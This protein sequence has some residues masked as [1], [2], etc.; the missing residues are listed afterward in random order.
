MFKR[1]SFSS[2]SAPSPSVEPLSKNAV[3]SNG[4]VEYIRGG[5]KNVFVQI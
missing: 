1:P 5:A 2:I 3:D 4:E